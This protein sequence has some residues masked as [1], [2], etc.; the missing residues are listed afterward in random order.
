MTGTDTHD[1]GV[2]RLVL[3]ELL[4]EHRWSRAGL[5]V[6]L[7]HID[8]AVIDGVIVTLSIEGLCDF[9]GRD[10]QASRCLRW[11]HD[12][13]LLNPAPRNGRP[14]RETIDRIVS[15]SVEGKRA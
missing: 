3:R 9:D 15:R 1:L 4:A 11:L 12:R 5:K 10:V 13:G 6:R 2:E 8:P 7:E 14:D